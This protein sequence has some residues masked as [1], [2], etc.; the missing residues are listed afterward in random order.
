MSET[1]FSQEEI[2]EM[3]DKFL[4]VKLIKQN[5][6]LDFCKT[7]LL[8]HFPHFYTKG[9]LSV[10]KVL[11]VLWNICQLHEARIEFLEEK[12]ENVCE[13]CGIETEDEGSEVEDES[14]QVDIEN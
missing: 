3:Y 7:T 6:E 13:Q 11:P 8:Q 2:E 1:E 5:N 12:L 9:K 10:N 14:T 4:Q